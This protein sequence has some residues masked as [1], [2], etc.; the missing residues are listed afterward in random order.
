M[1][2]NKV[3]IEQ[4]KR[5]IRGELSPREMYALER[6]AQDNPMLMDIIL[7]MEQAEPGMHAAN[8]AEIRERLKQRTGRGRTSRLSAAQRWAVAAS[9]LLAMTVSIVWFM[10]QDI[11]APNELAVAP[12]V[13]EERPVSPAAESRDEAEAPA[14]ESPAAAGQQ[15]RQRVAEQLAVAVEPKR[16]TEVADEIR[17]E[18]EPSL[19]AERDHPLLAAA[20]A[21]SKLAMREPEEAQMRKDTLN[22]VTVVGFGTQQQRELVGAVAKAEVRDGRA[23]GIYIRGTGQP[24]KSTPIKGK[25]L[26]SETQ[27]PLRGVVLQFGED[28]KVTTDS[29]GN[30]TVA[31]SANVMTPQLFGYE[32]Q[33][34]TVVNKDTL[35][36]AMKPSDT[37]LSEVV[38]VGY[39]R[40][41]AT[42]MSKPEP[43]TGWRAYNRYLKDAIKQVQGLQGA[44][45]LAFT[46]DDN[47]RPADIRV[48]SST[49]EAVNGR[50]IRLVR[51]GADWVPGKNGERAVELKIK[52]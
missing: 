49:N 32:M 9:V 41:K 6:R 25:V 43:A 45:T 20:P 35:V 8:L 19:I 44:V 7:G 34:L 18:A 14:Q 37:T 12:P 28:H 21:S 31:P 40:A 38:V 10:R 5:Y 24:A 42:K 3:D 51:D 36:F 30:F 47:G 15:S 17:V 29:A 26:D 16:E 33:G 11:Y 2:R 13:A 52:F 48:L 27:Q 50:A 23:A 1:E 39:G 22:E 46:V 4:V